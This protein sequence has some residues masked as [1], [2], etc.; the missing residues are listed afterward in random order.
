[1]QIYPSVPAKLFYGLCRITIL[2]FLPSVSLS[3]IF[4]EEAKKRRPVRS[5]VCSISLF[6]SPVKNPL[7]KVSEAG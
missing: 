7:E 2:S 6:N 5:L 1:L 3:H 4:D